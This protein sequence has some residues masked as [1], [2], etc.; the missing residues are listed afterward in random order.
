MPTLVPWPGSMASLAPVVAVTG[1]PAPAAASRAA[2][3]RTEASR[4]AGQRVRAASSQRVAGEHAGR[5]GPADRAAAGRRRGPVELAAVRR[6]A[7]R[8]RRPS[9]PVPLLLVMV[10]AVLITANA[11][12]L[13]PGR[14]A[15]RVSP[16]RALR[17]E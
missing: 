8:P 4:Q 1:A 6:R 16:A 9:L 14:A 12:A 5:A 7:G 17:T 15:A 11:V 13:W 3:P 2:V 10:P